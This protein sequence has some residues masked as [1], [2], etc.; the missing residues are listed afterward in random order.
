MKNISRFDLG[1][2]IAFVVVTALGAGAWYF[3]SGQLDAAKT[4]ASAAAADFDKYSSR[5][6]YLPTA[7]NEK[8]LQSNIDLMQAQLNPLIAS[9]L[10]ASGNKLADVKEQSPV[11]WKHD[12]DAEI[13]GLNNAAKVHGVT[14]PKQFYFGFSRY[15]NANPGDAQTVVLTKQLFGVEQ[16]AQILIN[17][18]VKSILTFRRTFEE[19]PV[20]N[21]TNPSAMPSSDPDFLPGSSSNGPGG[22]Y[23]AYP[24]EI[25]F[26]TSTESFRKFINGLETSPYV[27]VIRSLTIENTNPDSPQVGD[28]D[29]LA[30]PPPQG[31]LDSTPGAVSAQSKPRAPQ[32]LFG[33]EIIHVKARI[34]LI[35][36]KGIAQPETASA[37]GSRRSRRGP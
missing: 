27:F 29:K 13:L 23:T 30:G 6:T 14:V 10:Q 37:G 11:D 25:E 8:V 16:I 36:W 35:E 20:T 15:L 2:I 34:D 19:E 7:R 4:D 3:L 18:P 1:I 12:L 9:K 32:F 33:N 26:G 24:F 21:A 28:L 22:T 17:A 31:V 5:Q